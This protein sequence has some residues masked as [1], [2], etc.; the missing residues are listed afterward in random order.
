MFTKQLL[1]VKAFTTHFLVAGG[2]FSFGV[3]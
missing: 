2:F 3:V 1:G